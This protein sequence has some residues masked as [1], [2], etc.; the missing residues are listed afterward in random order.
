MVPTEVRCISQNNCSP[1]LANETTTLESEP[2]AT[3]LL[4][5][6]IPIFNER[7]N[8][9]LVVERVRAVAISKQIIIV[10][11]ASSDGTRELLRDTIEGKFSDV[12]V[13]FHSEN[14][15]KG[16]SIRTAIPHVTGKYVIIQDGDLEYSP[17]DYLP[18]VA[19][20]QEPGVKAVYGSRFLK[21][22]P[23]MKLPNKI[24]NIL[25]ALIVRAD[26]KSVV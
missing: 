20:L 9:A 19:R 10:D 26:R 5:V 18:I 22:Y 12:M 23:P 13:I 6:I 14:A 1:R 21:G 17:E 8:L 7:D 25:L 15:G 3:P 2:Q 11:D 4:S 24:V 16:A